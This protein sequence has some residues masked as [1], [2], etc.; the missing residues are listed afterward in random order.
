MGIRPTYRGGHA[1]PAILFLAV[2]L[3]LAAALLAAG[4]PQAKAVASYA[5]DGATACDDCHT[6]VPAV[7]NGKCITCHT[8]F[9]VQRPGATCWTCHNPGQDMSGVGPGAPAT[10]TQTCHR[11]DPPDTDVPD[12]GH[13]P[14]PQLGL[15]TTCHNVSMSATAANGSPHHTAN[16]TT[17]TLRVSPSVVRVRR[18]VRATGVVTPVGELN[19]KK[20][21]V[22]FQRKAGARWV[23][24]KT[25]RPTVRSVGSYSFTYRPAKKGSWRVRSSIPATDDYFGSLSR[26]RNFRV[27]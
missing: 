21:V 11:P 17:V 1:A 19:G 6:T 2:V 13:N 25:A 24:M 23:T 22:R 12:S 15:C 27:R 20:V 14:H 4:A 10:C 16:A 8:S 26:Y 18:P 5:H 3:L 7:T 9:Q